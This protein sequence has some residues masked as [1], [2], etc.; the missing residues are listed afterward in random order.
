M[1]TVIL[2]AS[3]CL[4]GNSLGGVVGRDLGRMTVVL[5]VFCIHRMTGPAGNR[6]SQDGR[7]QLQICGAPSGIP[8]HSLPVKHRWI[9]IGHRA[10]CLKTPL[11]GSLRNGPIDNPSEFPCSSV[12]EIHPLDDGRIPMTHQ[13]DVIGL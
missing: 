11:G 7:L 8:E 9:R 13:V 2:R 1:A 5:R 4:D 12:Q 3:S 6:N 10:G